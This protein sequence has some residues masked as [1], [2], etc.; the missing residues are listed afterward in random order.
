[1]EVEQVAGARRRRQDALDAR[2]PQEVVE[3]MVE[4]LA[5]RAPNGQR[6]AGAVSRER[7]SFDAVRN[8][9]GVAEIQDSDRDSALRR[10]LPSRCEKQ[11]ASRGDPPSLRRE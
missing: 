10:P 3:M 2:D 4:P 8:L 1:M 7:C 11:S 5:L 6:E 9:T